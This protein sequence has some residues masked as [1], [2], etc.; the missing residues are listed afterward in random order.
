[1]ISLISSV[2][3]VLWPLSGDGRESTGEEV[4]KPD[5]LLQF[6]RSERTEGERA[7]ADEAGIELIPWAKGAGR[8]ISRS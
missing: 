4:D 6:R 3:A 2:I 7:E 8:E 1:L 5:N